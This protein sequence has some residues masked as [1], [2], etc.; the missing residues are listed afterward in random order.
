M[1]ACLYPILLVTDGGD[2]TASLFFNHLFCQNDPNISVTK[3]CQRNPLLNG[4]TWVLWICCVLAGKQ[5]R[6]STPLPRGAAAPGKF[7]PP[8]ETPSTWT[9]SLSAC[10]PANRQGGRWQM[11]CEPEPNPRHWRMHWLE[12]QNSSRRQGLV[13]LFPG[14]ARNRWAVGSTGNVA[15][16]TRGVHAYCWETVNRQRQLWGSCLLPK[17]QGTHLHILAH[18]SRHFSF[19][20]GLLTP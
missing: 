13:V 20:I 18:F 16:V 8:A 4:G 5:R 10:G 7:C 1:H 14:G 3:I 17:E 15:S 6:I 11:Q 19:R 9:R 12:A 2:G